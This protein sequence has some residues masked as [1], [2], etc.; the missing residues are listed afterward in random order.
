MGKPISFSRGLFGKARNPD[1]L[2]KVL[3]DPSL[4]IKAANLCFRFCPEYGYDATTS[5]S[6]N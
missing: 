4:W 2:A 5:S 1:C 6:G 3:N